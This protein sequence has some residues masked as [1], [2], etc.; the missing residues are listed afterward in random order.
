VSVGVKTSF[1]VCT[2]SLDLQQRQG[3]IS[4]DKGLQLDIDVQVQIESQCRM[5]TTARDCVLVC[6]SAL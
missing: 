6:F 4:M 5:S 1:M 2:T 3:D